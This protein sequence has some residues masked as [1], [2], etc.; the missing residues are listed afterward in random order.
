[1][2]NIFKPKAI[3]NPVR[4]FDAICG[5]RNLKTAKRFGETACEIVDEVFNKKKFQFRADFRPAVDRR[6]ENSIR[7]AKH[8][9]SNSGTQGN[10][11]ACRP[12]S[13]CVIAFSHVSDGLPL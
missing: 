8:R 4:L 11:S 2:L 13:D 1:M 9:R 12:V 3:F 7:K 5:F 10:I 6:F